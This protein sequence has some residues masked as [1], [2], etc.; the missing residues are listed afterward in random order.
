[1]V[2]SRKKYE[3]LHSPG[4]VFLSI[5]FGN[6]NH[7]RLQLG[8]WRRHPT[9]T[10]VLDVVTAMAVAKGALSPLECSLA[11]TTTE[12][13]RMSTGE[14]AERQ[15]LRQHW[16]LGQDTE[17]LPLQF[18]RDVDFGHWLQMTVG[19]VCVSDSKFTDL[20]KAVMIRSRHG[21]M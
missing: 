9:V 17:E 15:R 19:S 14:L 7:R 6:L 1:M 4:R 16:R 12:S 8:S 18:I 10:I 11:A 5:T 13:E 2:F 3:P 21:Q 20:F